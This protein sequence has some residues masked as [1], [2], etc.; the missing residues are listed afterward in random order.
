VKPNE[1]NVMYQVLMSRPETRVVPELMEQCD[2]CGAAA[3]VNVRMVAGGELSFC[4]HHANRYSDLIAASAGSVVV[5]S[6]F[7]WYHVG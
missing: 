6:G 4:G 3:K 2:R 5:E 7:T 1:E